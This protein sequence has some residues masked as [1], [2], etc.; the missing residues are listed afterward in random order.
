MPNIEIHGLFERDADKLRESIF[1]AIAKSDEELAKEA[2]V[3]VYPGDCK[4]KDINGKRQPF[5]R[6]YSS[7]ETHFETLEKALALFEMDM[8]FISLKKFVPAKK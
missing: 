7:D 3:Y 8:E 1:K 5:L 4:V 6:I 2:V